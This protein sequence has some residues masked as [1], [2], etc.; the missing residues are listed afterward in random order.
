MC[1][2]ECTIVYLIPECSQRTGQLASGFYRDFYTILQNGVG[3]DYAIYAN[4]TRTASSGDSCGRV[5]RDRR[6]RAEGVISA[7]EPAPT[8]RVP[9]YHVPHFQSETSRQ[10]PY[11]TRPV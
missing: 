3:P 5:R 9:R 6:L 1:G 10:V 8:N 11:T 7:V 2:K 4:I